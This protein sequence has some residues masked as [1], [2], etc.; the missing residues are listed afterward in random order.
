[1]ADEMAQYATKDDLL[2]SNLEE[3]DCEIPGRGKVR[4]KALTRAQVLAFRKEGAGDTGET[5]RLMLAAA[6][7]IPKLTKGEVRLW[8]EASKAG[9]MEPVTRVV[10]RLSGMAE[11]SAKEAVKQFRDESGG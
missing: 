8:Q 11:D 4:V 6:F 7:V 2:V 5:E 1:M 9:E 3:E 10:M